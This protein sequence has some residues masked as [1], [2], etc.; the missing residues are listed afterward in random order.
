MGFY[1]EA[2]IITRS[3][4]EITSLL[5]LFDVQ[6]QCVDEWKKSDR[7]YAKGSAESLL[8]RTTITFC[9]RPVHVSMSE[10][11]SRVDN[12]LGQVHL[13]L[14][15]RN[16]RRISSVTV[17]AT[18]RATVSSLS[19]PSTRNTTTFKNVDGKHQNRAETRSRP[20]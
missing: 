5:L 19:Q 13:F 11:A 10:N 20:F 1:D 7:A 4:A 9:A 12:A 8:S 6:P 2:L 16:F 17:I 3:L 15:G 14:G 18:V